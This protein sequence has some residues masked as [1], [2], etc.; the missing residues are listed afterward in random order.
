M[1]VKNTDKTQMKVPIIISLFRLNLP[2]KYPQY[3]EETAVT[4][5]LIPEII[6]NLPIP[7]CKSSAIY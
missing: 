3:T 5:I 2:D 7:T 6:P 4:K 1:D